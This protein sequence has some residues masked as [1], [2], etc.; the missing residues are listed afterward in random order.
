MARKTSVKQQR[1]NYEIQQKRQEGFS[2]TQLA[3]EYGLSASTIQA[4]T[5]AQGNYRMIDKESLPEEPDEDDESGKGVSEWL[6]DEKDVESAKALEGIL[7]AS[8]KRIF[9]NGK[10]LA[11]LLFGDAE[12][13]AVF[14]NSLITR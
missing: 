2:F 14:I 3:E 5:T 10:G 6:E 7:D 12:Q 4:I 13:A 8:L 9:C 1:R 11:I